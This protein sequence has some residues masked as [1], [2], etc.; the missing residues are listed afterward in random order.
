MT[1]L[2]PKTK[3]ATEVVDLTGMAKKTS[4]YFNWADK[5]AV[6][7]VKDQGQCGSC[8]AFSTTGVLEGWFATQTG[9]LPSLSEQQLVDCS[10]LRYFNFGCNGGMPER[11]LDYVEKYGITTEANY[12]YTARDGSCVTKD[13]EYHT[14]KHVNLAANLE[15]YMA[16]IQDAPISVA[17][18]ATNFQF[19]NPDVS[20][21]FS[22]CATNMNHAVLGVGYD[23]ESLIIKNSWGTSWG[24]N[25]FIHLARGNTCGVL[26]NMVS[27]TA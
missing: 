13:G 11:A 22:D 4:G 21:V 7:P 27:V 17:L 5:G 20:K 3:T 8:W 14:T 25:G 26:N 19:Y 12:P 23:D 9:E 10:G 16:A 24:Y 2:I 18:D 1:K 15:T 6:T